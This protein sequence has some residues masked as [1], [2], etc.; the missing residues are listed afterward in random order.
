M[1]GRLLPFS[2]VEGGNRALPKQRRSADDGAGAPSAAPRISTV[3]PS[4]TPSHPMLVM[5]AR[6]KRRIALHG[7]LSSGRM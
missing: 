5:R 6:K 4:I 3:K 7:R 2:A 1:Q